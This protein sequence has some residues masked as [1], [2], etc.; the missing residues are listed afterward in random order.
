MIIKV[1]LALEVEPRERK[2]EGPSVPTVQRGPSQRGAVVAKAPQYLAVLG[3]LIHE[4]CRH[5]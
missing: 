2:V 1:T 5:S 3:R 4:W